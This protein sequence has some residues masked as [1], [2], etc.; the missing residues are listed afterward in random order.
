MNNI[1]IEG[2][3]FLDR[4]YGDLYNSEDVKHATNNYI[5][6]STFARI[7]GLDKEDA[8]Y[9]Y[10]SRLE[11]VHGMATTEHR[12]N[13]LKQLY[14]QKYVIK[15][16]DIPDNLDKKSIIEEQKRS[17][18]KWIDYLMS[19]EYPMWVKY[20][21]FRG[22]L[23]L[24]EY[25][26]VNQV[27]LERDRT[28]I[29]PFVEMNPK[30]VNNCMSTIMDN[31]IDTDGMPKEMGEFS[32]DKIIRTKSFKKLF[33]LYEKGSERTINSNEGEWKK[34]NK[35][36]NNDVV[37]LSSSLKQ[38][39][40]GWLFSVKAGARLFLCDSGY[41]IHVFYS[42]DKNGKCTE[43]R[44]A[45]VVN[46]NTIQ[47]IN[48]IDEEDNV[49][50]EMISILK[51]KLKEMPELNIESVREWLEYIDN[52]EELYKIIEKVN[53][54]E[55]LSQGEIFNLYTK[56]Y[57]C[58]H[59]D[60]IDP[61][62]EK[63]ISKCDTIPNYKTLNRNEKIKFLTSETN[64]YNPSIFVVEYDNEIMLEAVSQNGEALKFASP[65]LLNDYD[66]V[67]TAIK[68][69][70]K[71]PRYAFPGEELL[72]NFDFISQ[73]AKIDPIIILHVGEDIK[74]ND[75]MMRKLIDIH[76]M[77]FTEASSNIKKDRELIVRLLSSGAYYIFDDI[78]EQLKQDRNICLFAAQ[79]GVSLSD[80][81]E[82][83]HD[84]R[85]IVLAAVKNDYTNF[86]FASKKLQNDYEIALIVFQGYALDDEKREDTLDCLGNGLRNNFDFMIDI[87]K[88]NGENFR[89]ASDN[90]TNNRRFVLAA[91]RNSKEYPDE[92]DER[93]LYDKEILREIKRKH[94]K[95]YEIYT[96]EYDDEI[97]QIVAQNEDYFNEPEED[98]QQ[99]VTTSHK[100]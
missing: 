89:Y 3:K 9:I 15:E 27:Y 90:L 45:I 84:D 63:V 26:E 31:F 48:G 22:M 62:V 91:I 42:K 74:K 61:R 66:I 71:L 43:P 99:I 67:L 49:E 50:Q 34:Y 30:A 59:K 18:D 28:T 98:E 33:T 19:V 75:D 12:K 5:N 69:L 85:D 78:D 16:E 4:L 86:E 39:H 55:P 58:V 20:W 38:K 8:V 93:F 14:Y 46:G 95:D 80:M 25:D 11:E 87:I 76:A 68:K 65:K 92:I 13:L 37:E 1:D 54:N 77:A 44:I 53:N 56:K 72:N 100:R 10:L 73:V 29:S 21:A 2:A 60:H 94:P 40:T 82:K 70:G 52:L 35:N 79:H 47:Y 32:L 7:F 41:D 57:V 36:N 24:G 64:I 88:I 97:T 23:E 6:H 51:S 17:L 81:P 96:T 83:F